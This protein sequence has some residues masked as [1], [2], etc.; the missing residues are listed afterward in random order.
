GYEAGN[1]V[2]IKIAELFNQFTGKSAKAYRIGGDEFALIMNNTDEAKGQEIIDQI[3]NSISMLDN[4]E[5]QITMSFGLGVYKSSANDIEDVYS[6][7]L[8]NMHSNK[9]YDG[10]SISKKT[11]DIIMTTLFDKSKRELKHSERVG[12]ISAMIAN[13]LNL[14]T[15]FYNK[16]FLAGKLHDIGKININ[17]EILDK[18]GKLNDDEW[19]KMKKHP[20]SGFRILSSV[21]EYLEIAAIVLAHHER[22]DGTGYPNKVKGHDIHLASRI[23][24]LAD[25]YD[26]M[27]ETRTYRSAMTKEEAIEEIKRCSGS[28]FDPE[29]VQIFLDKI[30]D[31]I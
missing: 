29:L 10:S 11:I 31:K 7:A 28:Q 15:A 2:L 9:I 3:K 26:A 21:P 22:F 23:I 13:E 24:C 18:P 1:V 16:A 8:A 5:F 19:L 17:Q 6:K 27:T 20:E 4:S 25:A 12:Q 30:V 14:G